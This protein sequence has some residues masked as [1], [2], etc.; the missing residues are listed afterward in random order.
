MTPRRGTTPFESVLIANRGE[1]AVRVQRTLHAMGIASIAV[2]SDA[3]HAAPHVIDASASV[4]LGPSPASESYLQ[5]DRVI[6]AALQTGAQAIHPGYG[7][8]SESAAFASRCEE[9]GIVFIG[10]TPHQL[11]VF[12]LKH[13]ARDLAAAAGVPLVPGSGV[14]ESLDHAIDEAHRVG[15]PVML[16]ASAGG[17]GIGMRRCDDVDSLRDAHA[18]VLRMA[19]NSF[20]RSEVFLERFVERARHIEVQ[21]FGDGAGRVVTLGERDCSAQRRNQKVIEETP[22]PGIQPALRE[23]LAEAAGRLARSVDYRSAG[24]VEFVVD[25]ATLDRADGGDAWFLEMNTR[26]QVEHGVTELTHGIDLVEWMVRL[27]AGD[28]MPEL[29][30]PPEPVGSAVQVRLYAEDPV[31]DFRPSAGRITEFSVPDDVRCDTWV[32]AGTE[33]S[34]YYDPLVAKLLVHGNDRAEAVERMTAALEHTS[35]HGIATNRRFLLDVLAH[36]EFRAGETTTAL[37]GSIDHRPRTVG[38]VSPGVFTTVQDLPGRIGYWQVG[39]PPS[40]PMDD[41]S[42]ALVNEAVGNAPGAPALEITLAGPTLRITADTLFALGG[43]TAPTTLNGEAVPWW[44][45][46][47]APAGSELCIGTI[48][49]PGARLYLA[50]AGGIDVPEHLGSRSTFVL[51]GFGGHGG[52]TLLPGDVLPL[53][54]PTGRPVAAVPLDRRPEFGHRW[55]IGVLAGPHGAPDFFT[56]GDIE[57]L[58]ATDWEVHFNSDRTGIRLVGPA[59]TWARPDGGEAG[60]HPSNIHDNAYAVGTI[61]FT[62]DMP[63]VLGRDGPS[64]GGFVCPATIATSEFWKIG[65]AKAGD[66]VRFVPIDQTAAVGPDEPRRRLDRPADPVLHR[67]VADG[68]RPAVVYR[69]DGDRNLLIEY[70]DNVLD[71]MLRLRVGALMDRLVADPFDGMGELVPGIRSLQVGFDPRRTDPERVVAALVAAESDLPS[72]DRLEIPSRIVHLPLSWDDPA[73]RLAT[74]KYMNTVRPDAPWCP[75]NL[76]FIRR[77][78]GLDSVDDVRKIVFDASYLVLGLGDVYLGAPVATPIDPR[79]R[80]VTTKYN[81][82]RTW[83]AEN[84]VGIGGAYLCIYG[85][86]GPGGYQFVGRTVQVWNRWQPAETPWLLRFFDQIRWYPV[87]ADELLRLR[88]DVAAN[89]FDFRIEPTTFSVAEYRASLEADRAE[90][91]AFNE[92]RDAAFDAERRRWIEAG[93]DLTPAEAVV[94][95]GDDEPVPDGCVGV[96]VTLAGMVWKCLVAPGDRVVDGDPLVIIE[97]MKMETTITAPTTG[98]V[99]SVRVVEGSAVSP[100]QVVVSIEEEP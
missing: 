38:V 14:L 68:D 58:Y 82:A 61:D 97:S 1:I 32:A 59:P 19:S 22:A 44:T 36:P 4:R 92:R 48:D 5:I 9:A 85:M 47:V 18:A 45:P 83:T 88:D 39:V 50:F 79:H 94:A 43:A 62:G 67:L 55:E 24:T 40:G 76:E 54:E 57:Q 15:F 71:L 7:L 87:E 51:G 60:L 52:R 95:A 2:Y 13:T 86:E 99:E 66:R 31:N 98:V 49:G 12:G 70:G 46:V 41:R 25:A 17:G 96:T 20:G 33:I 65:Q 30:D 8:L 42:F 100:G 11:D 64:L 37:L 3:D 91:E 89:R 53:A 84:S 80:L 73:T 28:P 78:N 81:P 63:I 69:R 16:K 6:D 90:I 26:L 75:W 10:P 77:I 34:P 27:A 29:D 35:T 93:L 56:P 72:I 74:E 21:V 23:R